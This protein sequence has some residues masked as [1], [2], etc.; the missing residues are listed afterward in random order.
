MLFFCFMK[1]NTLLLP[2]QRTAS[3]QLQVLFSAGV[4]VLSS[5]CVAVCVFVFNDGRFPSILM[6]IGG[7]EWSFCSGTRRPLQGSGA[8]LQIDNGLS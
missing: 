6:V 3:V 4:V 1:F 5:V 7:L 2:K 8:G